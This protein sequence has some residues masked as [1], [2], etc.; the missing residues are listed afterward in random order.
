MNLLKYWVY[1]KVFTV[2]CVKTYICFKNKMNEYINQY[3]PHR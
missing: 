1:A 3:I 2:F